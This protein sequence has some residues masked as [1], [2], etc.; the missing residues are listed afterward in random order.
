MSTKLKVYELAK[1]LNIEAQHLVDLA[2]RLGVDVKNTMSILGTEEVRNIRD[3]YRKNK[4]FT[5]SAT[6]VVPVKPNVTEKRV[7]TTLI[8]RRAAKVVEEVVV[9]VVPEVT[10]VENVEIF[11][12]T[13]LVAEEIETTPL[14][15]EEVVVPLEVV[16]EVSTPPSIVEPSKE[17]KPVVSAK[18]IVEMAA[19]KPRRFFPS[20][21]KKVAT[22]EYLGAKV[23]PKVEK[24]KREVKPATPVAGAK[25]GT[26]AAIGSLG[27]G[28]KR[29]KEVDFTSSVAQEAAREAG[30]R[31]LLE[32]QHVV[33]KSADFL[34]RELIHS[35]KKKKTAASRTALKTE[36]TTPGEHKRIVEMG[37][38][39]TVGNLAKQMSQ[40][41][42]AIIK[43]L[44]AMGVTAAIND[45][46]DFDTA[47]LMA[48][49]FTFEVKQNIFKEESF[50]P[51]VSKEEGAMKPRGPV[52]TIMGHVDH[53]KTSLLDSIR[54][55]KVAAGEAGGIT[56]HVGAYTVSL[57]KGKITFVDTPG[58]EAFTA[59]RARGA[60]VTDLVVLVVSAVDGVMPQTLES[61]NHSKAANVPII[62][63]INKIDLPDG[64]PDRIKQTLAGYDL[65]PEEWGG[66][67]LYVP[68]SAKTGKGIDSLLENILLQAE[69]M[70]LK[71]NFDVPARG[72]VIES[73]LDK[74]R[75]PIASVLV[76]HGKLAQGELIVCGTSYGKV[77]AMTHPTTGKITEAFPSDP[78]EIL[79]LAAVPAV[80]D[81]FFVM[82]DEKAAKALI[83]ARLLKIGQQTLENR[84]K[85]SLEDLMNAPTGPDK[86]LRIIL[87]ADVAGSTE[88]LKESFTK[89]A[90]AK[91]KLKVLHTGTGGITETDIMLAAA[92]EAVI[93]GF[94]VRPDL[95]AQRIAETEGVIVRT[96]TIIYELLEDIKTLAEGLL[97]P[98]IKERV[99]GRAEVR[100]VFN[101]PKM[102]SIAGSAVID[103]K[104][105]RGC[106]LRLLRDN[107]VIYEGKI[108][109]LRRFKE[110][111]KEVASGFECGIGLE[112]Y[113]DVKL[114]DQF[115]AFLKEEHKS[116]L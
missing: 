39:I 36:I 94:N 20:I 24:V 49:E 98:E 114:G 14:E 40:K 60:K 73:R 23:G 96:Y 102:G 26:T 1:E 15:V 58:H 41:A 99:I 69:I 89:F 63:A 66:N 101:I 64:N 115:E 2:Q 111:V 32:R 82:K 75:G 47:T 83:D 106:Y 19:P 105:V 25:P 87:K 108:S 91:V 93:L 43:K 46:I 30:K 17:E 97:A 85:V 103:G 70:E 42:G 3:Y 62:V 18:L 81:D 12:E 13:I 59:M 48:H 29:V 110:D 78:V 86:E 4:V 7:G 61:I 77:R 112:N 74:H 53:G 68:V 8:R 104:V 44:M 27:V 35:M 31:R 52:V 5:K 51:V 50:I 95:K 57:P 107:R 10:E 37:D 21:I 54:K 79:G 45:N 80:G 88:A 11:D 116:T 55:T 90:S 84:P 22:E 56:Q 113:N 71:A 109:S 6:P 100:S 72:V 65:N 76:Q 16:A 33:F 92:S 34:K 67:T 28:L 38:S 9:E